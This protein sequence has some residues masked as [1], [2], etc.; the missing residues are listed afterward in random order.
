MAFGKDRTVHC[1]L[2][3]GSGHKGVVGLERP[4]WF[5]KM[6]PTNGLSVLERLSMDSE[7]AAEQMQVWFQKQSPGAYFRLNVEQGM[8]DIGAGDWK[9]LGEVTAHTVKYLQ[10]GRVSI[11]V[12][13]VVDRIIG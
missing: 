13:G 7:A 6:F 4:G 1:I 10:G 8:Y 5:Q 9:K 11:Q 12:D 3:I 2:S